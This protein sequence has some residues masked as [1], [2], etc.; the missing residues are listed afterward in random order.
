MRKSTLTAII[1]VVLITQ[2]MFS[3]C[4]KSESERAKIAPEAHQQEMVK[5]GLEESKKVIAAKVNGEAI[6]MFALLR[7][8]NTIASQY[9]AA[10]TPKTPELDQKIRTDALNTLIFQEL[11]VQEARK[12]GMKVKPE[13]IDHE[14]ESIKA[15]AGPGDDFKK[16]LTKNGFT[17]EELRKT[18][19][20]DALFEMIATKEIDEK[21]TVT[22]ADLRARYKKDKAGL[23]DSNHKQMNF[24]AAKSMIEQKVRAEAGEKRMREWETQLKKNALIEIIE[25]KQKQG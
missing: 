24:E 20:Q 19:E 9:A 22:D 17:E 7:E 2:A 12:R 13:V 10:G 6:T 5:K 1:M 8:M 18:I 3:A 11:G 15:K 21:I 25:Q 4:K 16:Y 14:I 23:K